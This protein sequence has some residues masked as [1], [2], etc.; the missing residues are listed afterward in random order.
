MSTLRVYKFQIVPVIQVV[1]ADGVVENEV[2]PP[3]PDQVF[4]IDGLLQYASTF[5]E[6]LA[7]KSASMNGVVIPTGGADAS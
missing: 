2:T 6:R 5:E 3:Q 1:D 7:E 4:G